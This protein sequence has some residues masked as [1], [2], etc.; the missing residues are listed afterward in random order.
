VQ[1]SDEEK[2]SWHDLWQYVGYLCG[3][4]PKLLTLKYEEEAAAQEIVLAHSYS[5]NESTTL[6]WN[7]ALKGLTEG[8]SNL[9]WTVWFAGGFLL[10]SRTFLQQL[11]LYSCS[12]EMTS[13]AG[14]E[15]RW[16]WQE[17]LFPCASRVGFV[18][19][20]LAHHVSLMDG[21]QM[22]FNS[23]I[24]CALLNHETKLR[25]R[26]ATYSD[27]GVGVREG[28]CAWSPGAEGTCPSTG[29]EARSSS[30]TAS[31]LPPTTAM[32]TPRSRPRASPARSRPSA[33]ARG[34]AE[35]A[36]GTTSYGG[37]Y[38][39]EPPR[40]EARRATHRS[41]ATSPLLLLPLVLMAAV[42]YPCVN[43]AID[44]ATSTTRAWQIGSSVVAQRS[45]APV[46]VELDSRTPII[47][48][49]RSAEL[50]AAT[51]V[52]SSARVTM[53]DAFRGE[54][55]RLRAQLDEQW[56][57]IQTQLEERLPALR[58]RALLLRGSEH[59]ITDTCKR[60]CEALE[61][62]IA[63]VA[64][65]SVRIVAAAASPRSPPVARARSADIIS[66]Q[67]QEDPQE[68]P[69]AAAVAD[70]TRSQP[71]ATSIQTPVAADERAD[72]LA[73]LRAEVLAL[74]REE[75]EAREMAK[76]ATTEA[77]KVEGEA[78]AA[79]SSTTL[80]EASTVRGGAAT[81]DQLAEAAAHQVRGDIVKRQ[82]LEAVR[83]RQSGR[84]T[85]HRP[86]PTAA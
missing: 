74:E 29:A 67:D 20:W 52:T 32:T 23:L 61:E 35:L 59:C 1:V 84:S 15:A 78:Q 16:L 2:Q 86:A 26:G 55:E 39:A 69:T 19:S 48:S 21:L 36:E 4:E 40:P 24:V 71:P 64:R 44:L 75:S 18:L 31:R 50:L 14:I 56:P 8:A 80:E 11:V 34:P 77:S 82:N 66:L 53:S 6:L 25:G 62:A 73:R 81:E 10:G 27:P 58:E 76:A 70:S 22:R 47:E 13:E 46:F 54:M 68:Q 45:L 28:K 38:D 3:V 30:R 72:K 9:P 49:A 33:I 60:A 5:P 57:E 17:V 79:A 65:S 41:A 43:Q 42:V 63:S 51:E 85:P 12:K 83:K 7:G 37:A